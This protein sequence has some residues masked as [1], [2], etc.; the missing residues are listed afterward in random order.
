MIQRVQSIFISLY[1]VIKFYLLYVSSAKIKSFHFFVH[2]FDLF[3]LMLVLIIIFSIAT[4]LSFKKRKTQIKLLFFLMTIQLIIIFLI[5]VLA[6]RTGNSLKYLL[7]HQTFLYLFG[8]F[9]LLLSLRGIKRDQKLID[10]ID[11]IR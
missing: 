11:R 3:S 7:N 6:Y 2:G 9:L 5:L 1:L 8:L 4:L 10:S